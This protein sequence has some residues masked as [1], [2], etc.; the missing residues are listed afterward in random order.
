MTENNNNKTRAPAWKEDSAEYVELC[1]LCERMIVF[2][3]AFIGSI[4]KS[5]EEDSDDD[6]DLSIKK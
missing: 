5:N 3:S 6:N 2:R 1:Q 4:S